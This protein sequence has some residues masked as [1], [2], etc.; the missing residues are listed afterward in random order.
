MVILSENDYLDV[1]LNS[2]V[3]DYDIDTLINLY[4]P[5]IGYT[6]VSIYLTFIVESRNQRMTSMITHNQLLNKLQ[7]ASSSFISERKKLEALGLIKTKLEV[8]NRTKIYHYSVFA[9]KTP[10]GF[11][12]D[13]LLFAYLIK[14]VGTTDANRL[15]ALYCINDEQSEGEDISAKF[16]DVFKVNFDD[17]EFAQT[18]EKNTSVNRRGA[19]INSGFDY[20][21]F[22]VALSEISQIQKI[23]FTKSDM[24]EIDRIATLNS[25][26]EKEA[27]A[28]VARI[29]D[30]SAPKGKRIN[31]D[32]LAWQL[33]NQSKILTEKNDNQSNK[34]DNQS[35]PIKNPFGEKLNL[36]ENCSP[37]DYLSLLQNGVPA[38]TTDMLVVNKISKKFGFSNG[39]INVLIEYVLNIN[40]NVLSDIVCEKYAAALSRTGVKTTI[41][42]MEYLS[43]LNKTRADYKKKIEKQEAEQS[44]NKE[45]KKKMNELMNEVV[46]LNDK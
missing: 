34:T 26:S 2:L 28:A 32:K 3:A 38:A 13:V 27:A 24:K 1:K 37:K 20:D 19:K 15:K 7:I 31:F 41:E 45:K 6:A 40:N 46:S 16:G 5:I 44:A 42:A 35:K 8:V 21:K 22:F 39:V 23:G 11:F 33:Q 9:P 43:K 29:Y 12:D 17:P 36:L 25:S 10:F 30:H 18:L 14:A 4:Q